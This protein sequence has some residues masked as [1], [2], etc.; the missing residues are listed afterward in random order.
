MYITDKHE[1]ISKQI[2]GIAVAKLLHGSP[3][4]TL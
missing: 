3:T 2:L 1:F 4:I